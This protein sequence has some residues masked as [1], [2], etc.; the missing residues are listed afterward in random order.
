MRKRVQGQA[1]IYSF[2]QPRQLAIVRL[3]PF[4][5]QFCMPTYVLLA[6]M[7]SWHTHQDAERHAVYAHTSHINCAYTR[8]DRPAPASQHHTYAPHQ[9]G[10]PQHHTSAMPA[11]GSLIPTCSF[12]S[13]AYCT[14]EQHA[15]M[16]VFIEQRVGFLT[17][18][19][20]K[21][22]HNL[23]CSS[24]VPCRAHQGYVWHL[25]I[26]QSRAKVPACLIPC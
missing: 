12:G 8:F 23:C 2:C 21:C 25:R 13:V 18:C 9:P 3:N 26:M 15:V 14:R 10:Q 5:T 20:I 4:L 19:E 16:V 22:C 24:S 17:C 1:V 6:H 7:N 11:S